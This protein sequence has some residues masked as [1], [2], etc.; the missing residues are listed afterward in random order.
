MGSPDSEW[1]RG[2]DN[3][4][5]HPVILTHSFEIAQHE[6]TQGEWE[7]LG[8][9][10]PSTERDW[11]RDCTD[12]DCPVGNADWYEALAYA[13]ALS[14]AH[15]PPLPP[16]YDLSACT[17]EPGT[18]MNCSN[19]KVLATSTYECTGY[20]LPTEAEWEYAARAGTRTPFYSG[21][22]QIGADTSTCYEQ[23]SLDDVAW[24]CMNWNK[25]SHPVARKTPNGWGLHDML[26]N[27]AE[28]VHDGKDDW[29][30]LPPAPASTTDPGGEFTF[31]TTSRV[32]RG[33]SGTSWS[34]ILRASAHL[35]APAA[36]AQP[37]PLQ[38]FRLVR[39]LE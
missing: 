1:G 29:V 6:T 37:G 23:A 10:N 14:L 12:D 20:R 32:E 36:I 27:V 39:T 26:G 18:G 3:E 7:R 28:W 17:G 13:N 11:G 8:F 2:R 33:G 22:I 24:Y 30:K 16:C 15:S 5:M 19:V 35:S 21:E 31:W 9:A 38:G 34:V 25:Q 4:E